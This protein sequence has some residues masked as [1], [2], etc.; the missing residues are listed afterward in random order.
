MENTCNMLQATVES[1]K[2]KSDSN[3]TSQQNGSLENDPL[4]LPSGQEMP[5]QKQENSM[6]VDPSS[7][8]KCPLTNEE[9]VVSTQSN[10]KFLQRMLI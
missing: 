2:E 10:T 9:K 1:L 4:S 7:V 5:S 6:I 8:V 3:L